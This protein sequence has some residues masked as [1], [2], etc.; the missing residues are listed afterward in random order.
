TFRPLVELLFTAGQSGYSTFAI[1]VHR[2][3]GDAFVMVEAPSTHTLPRFAKLPMQ[4][5]AIVVGEGIALKTPHGSVA[6]G[7]DRVGPGIAVPAAGNG[8]DYV[9][10][11]RCARILKGQLQGSRDVTITANPTVD[12]QT[13]VAT[14]DAL[15]QDDAG[16][17]FP[18]VFFGVAR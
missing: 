8:H 17:L 14:M 12:L 7:C 3:D 18:R 1:A 6:T 4:V 2:N 16:E 9:E 15:A 11:R 5:V 10:L 13:V